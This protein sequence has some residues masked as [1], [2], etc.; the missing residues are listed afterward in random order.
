[1]EREAF[2]DKH[3]TIEDAIAEGDKV[4]LRWSFLGTHLGDFWTP[5]GTVPATGKS[6]SVSATITYRLE[7]DRIAEEWAC[8]DWLDVV[9]Q[10][11]VLP[12]TEQ[13]AG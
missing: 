3:F 11:G 5:L 10:L 12:A 2:P 1:M 9:Q 7:G 13:P 4:V 6:I 8:F